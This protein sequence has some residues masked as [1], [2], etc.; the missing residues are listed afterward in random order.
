[1]KIDIPDINWNRLLSW[2]LTGLIFLFIVAIVSKIRVLFL[3][4]DVV[5]FLSL[6]SIAGLAVLAFIKGRS[7][8]DAPKSPDSNP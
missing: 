7:K 3:L 5:L 4:F 2:T 1:M 6:L 8:P